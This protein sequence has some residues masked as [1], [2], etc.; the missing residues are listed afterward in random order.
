MDKDHFTYNPFHNIKTIVG[1]R[2][3]ISGTSEGS[4]IRKIS[5][6]N[7][8]E[9]EDELFRQAMG[10][11]KPMER[12]SS[13][14]EKGKNVSPGRIRIGD[15]EESLSRLA[16][17]VENGV[18]FVVSDTP[19]Y[20]EGTGYDVPLEFARRLHRGDFSIQAHI[21][22]H[23][24]N[25]NDAREIFDGFLRDSIS[26]GKRAVLIVHGRGLSSAA[27][28]ILKN[29]VREW[30]ASHYWRKWIIAF[31]SARACDGGAGATYVLL[32]NRPAARRPRE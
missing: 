32:R 23:G 10:G 24:L 1:Q 18:G 28:P 25:A 21:D 31:S 9:R 8:P 14:P 11:V 3:P 22:L 5:R 17:L 26:T 4:L 15:D 20:M 12:D 29:K 30:L 19:E 2:A 13:A 27:E 7:D 16:A 6:K